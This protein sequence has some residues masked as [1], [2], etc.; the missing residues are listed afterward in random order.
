MFIKKEEAPADAVCADVQSKP[1]RHC[2]PFLSRLVSGQAYAYPDTG[3]GLPRDRTNPFRII[4]LPEGRGKINSYNAINFLSEISETCATRKQ[5][6]RN[7]IM[8]RSGRSISELVDTT[9]DF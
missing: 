1:R 6:A 4:R 5:A 3:S 7:R 2:I 9:C 8:L